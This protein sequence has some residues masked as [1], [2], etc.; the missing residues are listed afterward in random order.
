MWAII[1]GEGANNWEC[2]VDDTN[3]RQTLGH[4][5]ADDRALTVAGWNGKGAEAIP[6]DCWTP[7]TMTYILRSVLT[8]PSPEGPDLVHGGTARNPAPLAR[9]HITLKVRSRCEAIRTQWRQSGRFV[10]QIG[11]NLGEKKN[12]VVSA[13]NPDNDGRHLNLFNSRK[14]TPMSTWTLQNQ[15][16]SSSCE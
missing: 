4:R 8:I 6:G 14:C 2:W 10:N 12:Q 16:K 11:R 13:V 5:E 1:R 3:E 9:K 15:I 7:S